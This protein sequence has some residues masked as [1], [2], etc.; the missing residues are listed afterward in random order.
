MKSRAP[1]CTINRVAPPAFAL[2]ALQSDVE[3]VAQAVAVDPVLEHRAASTCSLTRRLSVSPHQPRRAQPEQ[4]REN[5]DEQQ[6]R[7]PIAVFLR[8]VTNACPI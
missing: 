1:V 3:R 6:E 4:Q 2:S 5:Q 8:K 7:R